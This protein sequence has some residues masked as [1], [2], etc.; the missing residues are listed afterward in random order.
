[1]I[2]TPHYLITFFS[3][4]CHPS[5]FSNSRHH[6]SSFVILLR[7]M[8]FLCHFSLFAPTVKMITFKDVPMLILSHHYSSSLA[9]TFYR[10]PSLVFTSFSRIF[11]CISH[12]ISHHQTWRGLWPLLNTFLD[13]SSCITTLTIRHLLLEA[14]T[15]LS[16][17]QLPFVK[18]KK[19]PSKYI[20][21]DHSVHDVWWRMMMDMMIRWC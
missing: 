6:S 18:K 13:P 15:T 7:S 21:K 4:T 20:V 3:A 10:P 12:V 11:R 9:N 14:V 17:R 1:M 5:S 2:M 19:S 16:V 8:N